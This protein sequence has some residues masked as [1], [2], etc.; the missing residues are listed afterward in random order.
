[1]YH[2]IIEPPTALHEAPSV[3]FD[4]RSDDETLSSVRLAAIEALD[5]ARSASM[6]PHSARAARRSSLDC[7]D[8][9]GSQSMCAT[10]ALHPDAQRPAD[11]VRES[12]CPAIAQALIEAATPTASKETTL[13]LIDHM[14]A[15][16]QMR[17]LGGLPPPRWTRGVHRDRLPLGATD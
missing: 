15:V 2:R 7:L 1:M 13:Q 11:G 17:A 12:P 16:E 10:A 6:R 14:L 3:L 9:K 4:A 5:M 8:L